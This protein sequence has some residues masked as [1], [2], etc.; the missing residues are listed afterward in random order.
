MNMQGNARLILGLCA[1][2]WTDTEI[3]D[4]VLWIETGD[5]RYNPERVE[6]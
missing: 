6:K 3:N 2:G 1:K 4:L 5:E